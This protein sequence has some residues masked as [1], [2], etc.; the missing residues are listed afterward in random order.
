MMTEKNKKILVF[1]VFLALI[2]LA[3]TSYAWIPLLI[4]SI[5]LAVGINIGNLR[6]WPGTVEGI[7]TLVLSLVMLT[8]SIIV[9]TT[10][11]SAI[12]LTIISTFLMTCYMLDECGNK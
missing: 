12:L 5:I 8:V 3:A 1:I 11:Y 9:I 2:V 7:I 4:V 10:G 6:C